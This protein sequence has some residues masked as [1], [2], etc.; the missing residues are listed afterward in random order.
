[1]CGIVGIFSTK[2]VSDLPLLD[3]MRDRMIHRGPD[4]H[5]VWWAPDSC[6][7]FGQRRL[8]IIDLSPGGH[9]PM[10]EPEGR[11]HVSFNGE[12][13]NYLDLR[14]ELEEKGIAFRSSS[15][16]EVLLQAFRVW[17]TGCLKKLRGMFAIS[18]YDTQARRGWLA[19]D[20]AGEKP[21]FYWHTPEKLVFGSELKSLMADPSFPRRLDLQAFEHYLA[22]GYV[23]RDLCILQGVKK[24]P[25]GHVL[26]YDV[27]R[28]T[29]DVQPYWTVPVPAPDPNVSDEELV[30]ELDTLLEDAVRHQMIADV[31]VG[32]LLS[33]GIDSSLVTAMAARISS[34]PVRTYTISFPGHGSM[35]EGPYA[36]MVA[37]H[38]GT[39]H[40]D[41][42][43]EEA[44][45]ELLPQLARQYDEPLADASLLP[46]Y[47]VSRL[48]RK[49]ATVALG[50]DGGDEL[51]GG[52]P[53]Y[54]WF[55]REAQVRRFVPAP[56]RRMLG[57]ASER[58]MPIGVRGRNRLIAFGGE[59]ARTIAQ[60]N[61]YFDTRTRTRLV[62][63]FGGNGS[64]PWMIPEQWKASLSP[65]GQ[66]P[67]QQATLLD[68]L[69]YLPDDILVKVD[70]ASMLTSLEVRAPFLDPRIIEF[71]FSRLPDRLRATANERKILPR[72]LA[73]RLLPKELDLERKQGFSPPIQKWF[74]GELGAHIK[75]VLAEADP[76]LFDRRVL[77]ELL[78]AQERGRAHSHRL[79]A[80][81]LFELWRREYGIQI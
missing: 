26:E 25:P 10:S 78:E 19:R 36:R 3:T 37:R 47:L 65:K 50:G 14:K 57:A 73:K 60:S 40:T 2:Q 5:G 49:H 74:Q 71:A 77:A 35:D 68:F 15:D 23:P 56:V 42:A 38:F 70:R 55:I 46:T 52:Y 30:E 13:Y 67:L 81:T 53:H 20:R 72:M 76:R 43:G 39:E 61:V 80:L 9:Q 48:I 44:T 11:Y 58:L 33:G 41:L 28:G 79:L 21:L 32:I 18:M 27:E 45:V 69:T 16:T 22:Y 64:R 59:F 1:M 54:S 62:P 75:E 8:A 24:L 17:G 34:K 6:A 31:P 29:I 51:F 7:G 4:D 12:I 63:L 66:S